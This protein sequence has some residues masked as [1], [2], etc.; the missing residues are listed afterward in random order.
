[1]LISVL[2]LEKPTKFS[3]T[4]SYESVMINSER[5]NQFRAVVSVSG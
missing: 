5:K 1:M 3:A 4:R 2:R